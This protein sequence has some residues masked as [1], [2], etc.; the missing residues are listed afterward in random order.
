M[1]FT[2]AV[3]RALLPRLSGDATLMGL[4]P[5]GVYW[6]ISKAGKTRLVIVKLM[7]HDTVDMF[8]RCAFEQPSYL[9][10]AVEYS[11][12]PNNVNAAAE[13][14]DALLNN[15]PL[16]IDGYGLMT[17][18]YLTDVRYQEPDTTNADQRWQHSGG[19]YLLM[20]APN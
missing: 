14:I 15:Q 17:A 12:S 19:V 1:A 16:T 8:G 9:V 18:Q 2:N 10:K 5:D 11:L 13:R 4:M 7:H 20:V 6:D 3:H